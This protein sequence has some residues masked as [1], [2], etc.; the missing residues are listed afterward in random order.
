MNFQNRLITIR[1]SNNLTQKQL[2][3]AIGLSEVG[4]QNY[5][6]GRRKPA[7]DVLI[8]LADYFDVSLDYLVGRSDD[9]AR[10]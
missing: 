5:E 6:S 7:F 2:A 8:A 1:K 10:H 3:S 4:V 9:P